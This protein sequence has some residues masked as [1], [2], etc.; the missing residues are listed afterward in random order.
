[1]DDNSKVSSFRINLDRSQLG[2]IDLN[3]VD[4]RAIVAKI[5]GLVVVF[6]IFPGVSYAL[7]FLKPNVPSAIGIVALFVT[8]IVML[9][10]LKSYLFPAFIQINLRSDEIRCR[11]KTFQLRPQILKFSEVENFCS[12]LRFPGFSVLEISLINKQIIK[13]K[14][15]LVE[16][17]ECE[18]VVTEL[19]HQLGK[20]IDLSS[21]KSEDLHPLIKYAEKIEASVLGQQHSNE[22]PIVFRQGLPG[23]KKV[24]LFVIFICFLFVCFAGYKLFVHNN[25]FG[26]V[27]TIFIS[28]I[29]SGFAFHIFKNERVEVSKDFVTYHCD[30]IFQKVNWTEA[31]INY[32]GL[33]LQNSN[34]N[35][36]SQFVHIKLKHVSNSSKDVTLSK[37]RVIKIKVEES[38]LNNF[39]RQLGLPILEINLQNEK[40]KSA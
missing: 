6:I 22:L 29:V 21:E 18:H 1:L 30:S 16:T 14:N 28:A 35:S 33:I 31:L 12:S 38:K 4:T 32:K 39:S 11:N 34:N 8:T 5:I 9:S 26:F 27:Q 13:F 19:N 20:S 7:L 23:L 3:F 24:S 36:Q 17:S 10:V 25:W 2:Q 37:N 40:N 15:Y